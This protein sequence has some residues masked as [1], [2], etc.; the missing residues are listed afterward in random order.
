MDW[1]DDPSG[2]L[3]HDYES[4]G[5]GG[6]R[7]STIL[8]YM[9]DLAEDAGGETVFTE[10]WPVGVPE[11]QRV[12]L[13]TALKDLRESGDAHGVLEPASWEEKMVAQCR[14]RLAVRP[15]AGRAVLFYSQ[16]PSGEPDP[17]SKHGGCPGKSCFS[18]FVLSITVLGHS[19][20]VR[21][22]KF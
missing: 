21:L 3:P 20:H 11:D 19:P 2:K 14:S 16:L 15:R 1:I 4:G 18:L 13:K 17:A 10:G 12:D 6:N 8:M 5:M 9:S 22:K 7:F